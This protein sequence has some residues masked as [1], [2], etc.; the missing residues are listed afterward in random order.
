M[1]SPSVLKNSNEEDL[2]I[3]YEKFLSA[4][5]KFSFQEQDCYGENL[6]YNS[7]GEDESGKILSLPDENSRWEYRFFLNGSF[8]YLSDKK[9]NIFFDGIA[10]Y[11]NTPL[12]RY[13]NSIY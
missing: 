5:F 12:L 10:T 8:V 4:N 9:T 3:F 11:G 2:Q 13:A 1:A 6:P 7:Y